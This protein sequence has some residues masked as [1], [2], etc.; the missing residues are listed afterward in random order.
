MFTSVVKLYESVSAE[1]MVLCRP[2]HGV[3]CWSI[4]QWDQV[5]RFYQSKVMVNFFYD[6]LD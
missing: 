4:Y 6:F 1:G 3:T 2:M 5:L